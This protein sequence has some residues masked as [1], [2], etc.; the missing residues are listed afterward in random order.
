MPAFT[1]SAQILERLR[2]EFPMSVTVPDPITGEDFTFTAQNLHRLLVID[3]PNMGVDQQSV[4]ALYARMARGQRACEK[5]AA[6]SERAYVAWKSSKMQEYRHEAAEEGSKKPTVAA[7]EAY[8]RSHPDY[9]R[10]SGAQDH[11]TTLARLFGDLKEAFRIKADVMRSM[12]SNVK[13]WDSAHVAE[14][15]VEQMTEQRLEELE[16]A[17]AAVIRASQGSSVSPPTAPSSV[18]ELPDEEE[19]DEEEEDE[20]EYEE[21]DSEEDDSEEDEYEEDDEEEDEEDDE[22]PPPPPKKKAAPRKKAA[23]KTAKTSKKT[24]T[25][26]RSR[27][28]V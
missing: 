2:L 27:R 5:A 21:D 26:K 25:K 12:A 18:P 16:D 13:G 8:Y 6:M 23:K 4:A 7:Q 9:E 22:P 24:A 3:A 28:K 10:I 11:W 17:A 1:R 20:D 19:Y 15:K 14:D